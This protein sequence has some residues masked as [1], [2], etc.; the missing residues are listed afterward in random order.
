MDAMKA[1]KLYIYGV[2]Q[3]VGFRPFVYRLAI[4]TAVRGY[5]RN[6]SGSGVEIHV[7]GGP[8]HVESFLKRFLSE[9]PQAAIVEK[10]ENKQVEPVGFTS[11]SIFPSEKTVTIR[12]MIPPD[13]AICQECLHEV[14]TR[15]RW[16]QYPFN[17]C[18]YCG[19]RYSMMA[20]STYDRASTAMAD[21]PLCDDCVEDYSDPSNTRRFHAQGISCPKCGPKPTLINARNERIAEGVD[22]VFQAAELIGDGFVVA[23]KGVGGFHFATLATDD[24]VVM[25]IRMRKRRSMKPFAVMGLDLATL[26]EIVVIDQGAA[27]VLLSVERPIVLLEKKASRVSEFVAPGLRHLGVFLPYTSLHYLLLSKLRDK[28]CI[29]TSGNIS[30]EP[31]VIDDS[32]ALTKLSQIA[33]Y[34]LIHNRRIFHRVDDSVVRFSRGKTMLLRRG[35]GYAPMWITLPFKTEK[36]VVAFGAMLQNAGCIVFEDKAVLTPYIGDVDEFNTLLEL[37]QN[38]LFFMQSYGISFDSAVV[39]CDKHPSYPS[40]RLA[41]ELAEKNKASLFMVQHHHA[42]IL[43]VMVDKGLDGEV[44]GIAVDG[45]GY[46]DDGTVWGGEVLKASYEGY[47]RVG[48]LKP[49]LMPGGD[50]AVKYPSRMLVGLLSSIRTTDEISELMRGLRLVEKG[51]QHGERELDF[52]LRNLHNVRVKTSSAG[53]VF[54][55]ASALLGICFQRTYEGEPAIKLE[56]ASKPTDKRFDVKIIGS[57]PSIV[58]TSQLFEDILAV[59]EDGVQRGEIAYMVQHAVGY[60][61][62]TI[63]AKHVGENGLVVVSGGAAVNDIFLQGVEEALR[64]ADLELVLPTRVPAND[65]GIALGQAAAAAYRYRSPG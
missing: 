39:V 20:T 1:V 58:D 50:A 16:Y 51:F 24:E 9:K 3:G 49:Q 53:R 7:E 44:V 22:A 5:V 28:F 52:V 56:A 32:T 42:H 6:V 36:N 65:G 15:T 37:D 26:S 30:D 48:C 59:L 21:F 46:G 2:V 10:I 47:I 43:S 27:D 18:V 19:P 17:S 23:V 55:A 60:G 61:L 57:Q 31:M 35:R 63:A 40:T 25:K 41:A 13:F 4:E 8:A 54:D 62:G 34:F 45:A 12:S 38:V 64:S 11:F 14:L 29:M 33:D